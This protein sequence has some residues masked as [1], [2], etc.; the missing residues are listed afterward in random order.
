MIFSEV[1]WL[2]SNHWQMRRR[3]LQWVIGLKLLFDQKPVSS[4]IPWKEKSRKRMLRETCW[5]NRNTASLR[6]P[7]VISFQLPDCHSKPS[8]ACFPKSAYA[9]LGDIEP[10]GSG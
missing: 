3:F 8:R 6:L 10:T 7:L 2:Y 9:V 4:Q 5:C 1:Q